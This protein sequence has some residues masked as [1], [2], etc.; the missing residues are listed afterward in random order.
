MHGEDLARFGAHPSGWGRNKSQKKAPTLRNCGSSRQRRGP[1]AAPTLKIMANC[2]I[3]AIRKPR[4]V[5]YFLRA[6]TAF[7]E[8]FPASVTAN[9]QK[10]A[11]DGPTIRPPCRTSPAG[12][13]EDARTCPNLPGGSAPSLSPPAPRPRSNRREAASGEVCRRHLWIGPG[14]VR[15]NREFSASYARRGQRPY[16]RQRPNEELHHCAGLGPGPNLCQRCSASNPVAKVRRSKT[17]PDKRQV[18]DRNLLLD[19]QPAGPPPSGWTAVDVVGYGVQ[20]WPSESS[21]MPISRTRPGAATCPFIR[22]ALARYQPNSVPG[23]ELSR[24]SCC[25]TSSS[26]SPIGL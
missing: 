22:L 24:G 5:N 19:E 25:A 13:A 17:F 4:T 1:A 18:L 7:R 23:D 11:R 2:T 12:G 26:S 8:Y 15:Q 9:P 10:I 16:R 14:T 6:T 3:W 20:Y 21:G